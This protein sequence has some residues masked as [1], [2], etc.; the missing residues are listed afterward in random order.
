MVTIGVLALQ[1]DVRFHEEILK[2]IFKKYKIDDGII[3]RIKYPDDLNGIDGLIIPG[4]ESTVIGVLAKRVGL[5]EVLK[6][7]IV[8]G[9]PTLLVCAGL[10]FS[11]KMVYDKTVGKVDQPIL[12]ILDADIER[13]SFGTQRESFET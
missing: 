2:N 6:N 12:G 8:N 13:N 4:G 9:L 3:K 11:A 7:K 10:V 5:L 1:G